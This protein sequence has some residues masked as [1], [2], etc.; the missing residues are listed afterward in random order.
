MEDIILIGGGGHCKSVIDVIELEKRF[1]IVGIVDQNEMFGKEILGY[2]IIGNDDNIDELIKTCNNFHITIGHIKSN[3]ARVTLFELI[4]SKKG[5]FPVI[6]SPLAYVSKHSNIKEGSIIMHHA[7]VN[8]NAKIGANCIINTGAVIEHDVIIE[9]NCHIST[10]AYINGECKVGKNSFVGSNSTL[11]Q[12][13]QISENNII[14]AGSVV[15]K[16]TEKNCVYAGN[17]AQV[18][19]KII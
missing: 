8:A 11:L 7:F 4:K 5:N 15:T 6:V 14:A 19:K 10:G 17:P 18:K 2:K 16:S 12:C 1:N 13:I 9:D 3:K